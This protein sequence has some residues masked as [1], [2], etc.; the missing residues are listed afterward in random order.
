MKTKLIGIGAMIVSL[1]MLSYAKIEPNLSISELKKL[2]SSGDYQKW[3]KPEVDSIVYAQG[4]EDIGILG[5]PE[6]PKNNPYTE[7]KAELGKVLFF[8]PRLSKSGQISCANCHDP[9]LNW[10][11]ARR[12]S[13][14]EGRQQGNR[15]APS[16]M[17]IA[18]S[19]VFFWDGRA[20]TLEDQASFPIKDAKEMN[21]HIDLATKRLNKIK[22]YKPYFKKAFGKEKLTQE[23]I[24]KAIATFERTLIT[25]KSK[26][27]RFIEGDS[28]QLTNK[29]VEGLHL[30]RT[31]A[32]CI[33]CHNTANFADNKFH[34]IGLTYYGR[35]YQDLGRYNVTG[36]AENVGEFKTQSLRGAAQNAPYMHNGLFPNLRGVLNIYNAG[37]PQPKRK[38]NQL[39]DTLFPTTSKLIQK[40]NLSKSELDALEDFIMT[41]STGAYRMRPPVLP[42]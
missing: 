3:P 35:E 20:E 7:E 13:Y 41:L 40:L 33:N 23:E 5:K 11:D 31:K 18:Y 12:V 2:Y 21:F 6:F 10:G 30:F 17:N 38:E 25:P 14:G 15:N 26:F 42:Q 28:T 36:K 37:M 9:E 22:G 24:L 1:I 8:D 29:Q 27:D 19:K 16:L 39:N 32:R 34:N 4:F